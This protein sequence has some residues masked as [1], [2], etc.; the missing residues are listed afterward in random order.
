MLV[1]E[2]W[3]SSLSVPSLWHSDDNINVMGRQRG[4][5]C[6]MNVKKCVIMCENDFHFTGYTQFFLMTCSAELYRILKIPCQSTVRV[7]IFC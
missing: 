2:R 1:C 6:S 7:F 4:M 5:V 3:W